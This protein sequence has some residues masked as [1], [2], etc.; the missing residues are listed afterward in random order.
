MPE[1]GGRGRVEGGREGVG[2]PLHGLHRESH[3]TAYGFWPCHPEQSIYIILGKL[4]YS[5]VV[6]RVITGPLHD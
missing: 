4:A 1:E 2:A 5:V 3:Q 6:N